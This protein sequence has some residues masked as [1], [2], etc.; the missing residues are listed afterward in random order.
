MSFTAYIRPSFLCQSHY[1]HG[2]CPLDFIDTINLSHEFSLLSEGGTTSYHRLS[3]ILVADSAVRVWRV[4][5][6]AYVHHMLALLHPQEALHGDHRVCKW[7]RGRALGMGAIRTTERSS[8]RTGWNTTSKAD[9][10]RLPVRHVL[11]EFLLFT[12]GRIVLITVDTPTFNS[13]FIHGS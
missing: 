3:H 12:T 2:I 8:E 5:R 7:E 11:I 13:A 6:S 9:R 10:G 1:C 4:I